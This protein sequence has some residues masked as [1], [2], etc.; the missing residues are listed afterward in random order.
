MGR[1]VLLYFVSTYSSVLRNITPKFNEGH[2]INF[3][4]NVLLL[5][6]YT[7]LER[8]NSII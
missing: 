8:I 7:R 4:D 3:N 1:N 5:R 6:K 2:I